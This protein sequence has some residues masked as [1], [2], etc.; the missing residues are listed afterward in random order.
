MSSVFA[1]LPYHYGGVDRV[2]YIPNFLSH[3]EARDV[4]QR[5]TDV[6]EVKNVYN[7]LKWRN[8]GCR[9]LGRN[10]EEENYRTTV[11]L[12]DVISQTYHHGSMVRQLRKMKL[13]PLSVCRFV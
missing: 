9:Q 12:L 5:S 6:D 8:S 2:W 1:N 10:C 11:V 13:F 3:V 4:E 7:V